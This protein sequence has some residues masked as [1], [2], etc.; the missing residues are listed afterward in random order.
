MDFLLR[1]FPCIY[2]DELLYSAISRYYKYTGKGSIKLTFKELFGD[3]AHVFS[4]IDFPYNIDS[5]IEQFD[6]IY[7]YT[8]KDIILN[9]TMLPLYLPFLD[10][11]T[12]QY[13]IDSMKNANGMDLYKKLGVMASNVKCLN[14]L[15]YCPSC[16]VDDLQTYGEVYLHR[17]HNLDGVF[18]CCKHK[19]LLKTRCPTCNTPVS[20]KDK[21]LLL[22][23]Q[24]TCINGHNLIDGGSIEE[25]SLSKSELKH[26]IL[27]SNI[28]NLDLRQ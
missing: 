21:Y 13:T 6:I 22:S 7:H 18:F 3:N 9:F 10:S 27:I 16:L 17:S 12:Q 23:L 1:F 28:V 25:I 14:D 26:H 11:S 5:F 24:S 2:P 15:K 4:T 8:S 20:P 19:R